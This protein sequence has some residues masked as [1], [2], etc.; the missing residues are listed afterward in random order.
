MGC[1]R[2]FRQLWLALCLATAIGV[3]GLPGAGRADQLRFFLEYNYD[4]S[5]FESLNRVT[6][7]RTE[8]NTA[9]FEQNYRL[10]FEKYFFPYL[11]LRGGG[12]FERTDT[13]LERVD[14]N[15]T[16]FTFTRL[17][18][19][20]DLVLRSPTYT[21]GIGYN[22]REDEQD[23][24]SAPTT[25]DIRDSYNASFGWAPVDLPRVDLRYERNDTYD[26]DRERRDNTS[27]RFQ[28]LSEFE[29]TESVDLSYQGSFTRSE[30]RLSDVD[31]EDTL[32]SGRVTYVDRYFNDRVFFH[33]SYNLSNRET[34]TR[35]RRGGEVTSTVVSFA[36]LS[37]L[38]DTPST[39]ALENSQALVDGNLAIPAGIDLGLPPITEFPQ[40]R[41]M[42]LDLLDVDAEVNGLRVF[43]DPALEL[44]AA[45]ASSYRWDVYASSNNQ[46][47]DL[48][49]ANAPATF[50][51]LLSRF[52]I[53]FGTVR[54]RYIKVVTDP[55]SLGVPGAVDFPDVFVTELQGTVKQSAEEV[56]GRTSLTSQLLNTAL[57][58]RLLEV[59]S[60]DYNFSFF[61]A[62]TS[63]L[64]STRHSLNNGLKAFHR[65]NPVFS[66]SADVAR[67]DAEDS[68]S[69]AVIYRY[70]ASLN[71][72]PLPTLS[73][74]LTFS[75]RQEELENKTD[76]DSQAT[77]A[78]SI[79]LNTRAE[80]YRG[81]VIVVNGGMTFS[82]IST[83]EEV[84]NFRLNTGLDI[85]PNPD[86]TLN[87]FHSF[88]RSE[89]SGL[90]TSET[91]T[92]R[93]TRIAVAYNPLATLSLFTSL[94]YLDREG[95]SQT[96][97]N[98]SVNWSPFR[99]GQ[100]Q[101]TFG[102]NETIN[103]ANDSQDRFISP[104]VRWNIRPGTYLDLNYTRV[105][106]E[107]D[108]L[109]SQTDNYGASLR[110]VF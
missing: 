24:S 6:G 67:E 65:F 70:S 19:F 104:G 106:S 23:S 38:D 83:G 46:D 93:R 13:T 50:D 72:T 25:K 31:V 49:Q 37:A 14:E 87:L 41:N 11:L 27:Q 90:A 105:E 98:Y 58:L 95:G 52:D 16:D 8:L 15:D 48:V 55:L 36:G 61:Y 74:T 29:P 81:V 4:I 1:R 92:D 88:D 84:E 18:P 53:S 33:S 2:I 69:T 109:E 75:G 78:N 20:I 51:A 103:S 10:N 107:S 97:Q 79:F 32:H 7:E 76:Q 71:A 80:L 96:L 12:L 35:A 62:D 43:I 77:D 42:G 47:W 60:V 101:F 91:S 28:V 82:N 63:A 73:S 3:L 86:L 34:E 26:A 59:P 64:D 68:N 100:L 108:V 9:S 110:A 94:D 17:N 30:D 66:G 22:R 99:E 40:P 21:A 54:T 85:T 5:D 57:R 45:V 102:Y 89:A 56:E 44:S 39:G